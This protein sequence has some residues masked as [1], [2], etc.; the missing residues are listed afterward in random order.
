[1]KNV[2]FGIL[3]L[4]FIFLNF[5]NPARLQNTYSKYNIE[6]KMAA[7]VAS[8]LGE[9]DIEYG[10]KGYMRIFSTIRV[11]VTIKKIKKDFN[12]SLHLKYYSV[13]NALSSYS[14]R[15]NLKRGED[16][17][18]YFYPF[19]NTTSPDFTVAFVD[20]LGKEIESFADN[21]EEGAIDETSEIV[22]A[23]LLPKDKKLYFTGGREFRIKIIY[24]NEDQIGGDYRA[25]NAFDMIVKPD[26]ADNVLDIKTLEILR[27][28][29]KQGK[30]NIFEREVG[31]FN[32]ARLYLGKEDRPEWTGKT[33]LVLVPVLG[34]L[35]IKTG[36]YV[37][38]IFIYIIIVAPV[39]YF[40]LA[41]RRRKVEYWIFVPVWSLI[42]ATIIYMVSSDS[43]IDGMYMNYVSVL[44]L[45]DDRKNENVAFSVTNSS[46]LPYKLEISNGYNVESLYGS[47]SQTEG[48]DS[49][50][51]IYNIESKPNGADINV[52]EATAFD[53]LFL[54]AEGTPEVFAKSAGKIYRDRGIL[55]GEFKN[56]TVTDLNKVFAVYDDEIIYIGDIKSGESKQFTATGENVFLDDLNA[57]LTDSAFLN[58]I[59]DFAYE[60]ENS[61]LKD[62]MTTV[63]EKKSVLDNKKPFFVALLAEKLRG[64]F[65]SEVETA[66][67]YTIV[68]LPA[69][70][71]EDIGIRSG[72]F[73][74][75]I[76][77]LHMM[78]GDIS[79]NF[80]N[81]ALVNRN[82]IDIS[83]VTDKAK[84]VKCIS[85]L[86]RYKEDIN[87]CRVYILNHMTGRYDFIFSSDNDFIH[88]IKEYTGSGGK[89]KFDRGEDQ[90]FNINKAYVKDG[91]IT[92]RYEVE[93]PAY[94]EISAFYIPNIPKIS[95]EYE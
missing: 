93:Q 7:D 11:K 62:L 46:S 16:A 48:K 20:N 79:Y 70:K 41:K 12:G 78:T 52:M 17:D 25:L 83:Y 14:E 15:I 43:R 3:S 68:I 63:L 10:I 88:K 47:Y 57:R 92:L 26:D 65:A 19:L 49:K 61:K 85:L 67:G 22:V 4:I 54:K 30:I 51:V 50:R 55:K 27:E 73:I 42:F 64:E 36:R 45:R 38:I 9:L 77:K 8:S 74:N 59:F 28:R 33:E 53:T 29:E 1:M 56:E 34:N 39:T 35:N 40:I 80:S 44:D 37:A 23:S 75:A 5:T 71:K 72:N 69:D 87:P 18:F 60:G 66:N 89:E 2:L 86:S 95:L 31:D 91:K 13:G 24:L 84:T 90:T 58:R 21:I 81:G 32:L 6:R 94:D 76:G 82:S